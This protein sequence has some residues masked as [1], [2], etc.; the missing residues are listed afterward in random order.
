M[1]SAGVLSLLRTAT[2]AR[3]HRP[4]T[5]FRLRPRPRFPPTATLPITSTA[6]MTITI[7]SC[8]M[9]SRRW[10]PGRTDRQSRRAHLDVPGQMSPAQIP[11]LP[12]LAVASV[13]DHGLPISG[14]GP[15][16]LGGGA[17]HV[18]SEAK[19]GLEPLA[20][21][22]TAPQRL[23]ER[24]RIVL[25]SAEGR[26]TKSW[27]RSWASIDSGF[28]DGATGGRR[29]QRPCRRRRRRRTAPRRRTSRS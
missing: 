4:G 12:P 10:P 15:N 1:C 20:R 14:E 16:G 21:A 19:G 28:G 8:R 2:A 27:P 7:T 17:D 25:M 18:D 11:S 13:G 22:R 5:A 23:V 24:C 26:T 9:R 29:R 3:R 6:T